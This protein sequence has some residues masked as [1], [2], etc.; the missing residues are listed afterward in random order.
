MVAL[1][2]ILHQFPG[3]CQIR[4]FMGLPYICHFAYSFNCSKPFP[5]EFKWGFKKVCSQKKRRIKKPK[6]GF[7]IDDRPNGQPCLLRKKSKNQKLKLQKNVWLLPTVHVY[8][9][10]SSRHLTFLPLPL[11]S[12]F[13]LFPPPHILCSLISVIKDCKML[14][15]NQQSSSVRIAAAAAF[16]YALSH[17]RRCPKQRSCVYKA[18]KHQWRSVHHIYEMLGPNY[19]RQ[20]YCMSYASFNKLAHK[21]QPFMKQCDFSK[22]VHNGPIHHY[23]WVACAIHYFAGGSPYDLAMTFGIEFST[24]VFESA[25]D[26]VDAVNKHQEFAIR[27]PDSHDEQWCIVLDFKEE[28]CAG[29]DC[30]AGTIGWWESHLVSQAI[31][32]VYWRFLLWCW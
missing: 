30:C 9:S 28:S 24:E 32:V 17:Q 2:P 29:F 31:M 12:H 13:S 26:F 11:T 5:S 1:Q 7:H 23:I 27:Y 3:C 22:A 21:L 8:K 25:W 14:V 6:F 10:P 18:Q 20:A 16:R 15:S 19:F 4:F